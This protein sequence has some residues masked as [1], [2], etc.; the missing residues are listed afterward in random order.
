VLSKIRHTI[1][2]LETETSERKQRQAKQT[3]PMAPA[4]SKLA[5]F[6]SLN[7]CHHETD[8]YPDD[9]EAIAEDLPDD[10]KQS[11]E[12]MPDLQDHHLQN[13]DDEDNEDDDDEDHNGDA[14]SALSNVSVPKSHLKRANHGANYIADLRESMESLSIGHPQAYVPSIP[15]PSALFASPVAASVP[16]PASP[17]LLSIGHPQPNVAPARAP[18]APL[19]PVP[20]PAPVAPVPA[21]VAPFLQPVPPA[22]LR[23]NLD[24]QVPWVPL[25]HAGSIAAAR[26]RIRCGD[27]ERA[28]EQARLEK[29]RI[30]YNKKRARI[31]KIKRRIKDTAGKMRSQR[32]TSANKYTPTKMYTDKLFDFRKPIPK[33][34]EVRILLKAQ[35][36]SLK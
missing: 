17:A 1:F 15:P 31:R 36:R 26:I 22:L 7:G 12:E 6:R 8:I 4:P 25:P 21:P 16:T 30:A 2:E 23:E 10:D 5:Y 27:I 28:R 33:Y 3:K 9:H 32:P 34:R 29:I 24:P 19:S 13:D 11:D 18:P 20:V 35:G 14:L